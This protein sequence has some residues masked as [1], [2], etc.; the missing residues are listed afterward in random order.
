MR[1]SIHIHRRSPRW[2]AGA[3]AAAFLA[4]APVAGARPDPSTGAPAPVEPSVLVV[5]PSGGFDWVDATIGA[6][7]TAGVVLL[8]G[9]AAAGLHRRR[10]A[11]P[12]M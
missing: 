10:I 3:L 6:G 4:A 2:I 8:A 7:A 5:A 11:R 1:T 12:V 9:G